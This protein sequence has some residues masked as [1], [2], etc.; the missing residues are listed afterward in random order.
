[1]AING[2]IAG[3]ARTRPSIIGTPSFKVITDPSAF[4]AGKNV[5]E[6]YVIRGTPEAPRLV[7]AMR[8]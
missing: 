8:V 4:V 7:H 3:I 5:V 2:V 1:V 6:V